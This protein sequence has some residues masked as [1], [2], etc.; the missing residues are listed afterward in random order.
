MNWWKIEQGDLLYFCTAHGRIRNVVRIQ[1]ILAQGEGS[2]VNEAEPILKRFNKRQ[3]KTFCDMVNVYVFCIASICFHGEELLRQFA[4]HQKYRRSHNET[5]V[6][7][8]W[9]TDSRT[10]RRDL[11]IENNLLGRFFMEAFLFDWWWTS[12]E[13][14]AHKCLRILD[15]V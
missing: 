15:S 9:G 8:I 5:D 11:W 12:H 1:I 6:R 14:L 7:H 10:I 3:R 2:S 13:S 4:L